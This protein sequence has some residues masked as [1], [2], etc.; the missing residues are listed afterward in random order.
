MRTKAIIMNTTISGVRELVFI[1]VATDQCTDCDQLE[2]RRPEFL[3]G[4]AKSTEDVDDDDRDP[5]N[6]Y[7]DCNVDIFGGFPVLHNESGDG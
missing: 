3:L 4:K 7:P 1:K 6:G 2:A 5:E